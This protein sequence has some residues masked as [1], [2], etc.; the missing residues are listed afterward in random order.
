[1][2]AKEWAEHMDFTGRMEVSNSYAFSL[3]SG[4]NLAR[5]TRDPEEC[6]IMWYNEEKAWDRGDRTK[7]HEFGHYTALIWSDATDVGCWHK[8]DWSVCYYHSAGGMVPNLRDFQ[9]KEVSPCEHSLMTCEQRLGQRLS[10]E[11]HKILYQ[12]LSCLPK[13]RFLQRVEE[14]STTKSRIS[15]SLRK[16][17]TIYITGIL[18]AGTSF[19]IQG[20]IWLIL[21]SLVGL[22][23]ACRM[24][25]QVETQDSSRFASRQRRVDERFSESSSVPERHNC[26]VE[27][28]GATAPI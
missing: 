20:C 8:G 15:A 24:G 4:E 22:H 10:R 23:L 11:A 25:A 28:P 19:W 14:A 2:H 16:M 6:T 18:D 13:R 1:M 7:L 21:S 27:D 5:G 9:E 12:P 17:T 26:G 3:S